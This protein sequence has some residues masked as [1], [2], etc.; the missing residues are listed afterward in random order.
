MT[1]LEGKVIFAYDP[2]KDETTGSYNRDYQG[3]VI[4]CPQFQVGEIYY[5]YIGGDVQGIETDASMTPP[6]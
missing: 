5:V 3:A 6:P 2:D 4:S 1:D